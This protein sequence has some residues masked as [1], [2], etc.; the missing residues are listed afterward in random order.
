MYDTKYSSKTYTTYTTYTATT[1]TTTTA[2]SSTGTS[3]NTSA[4]TTPRTT[5]HTTTCTSSS[6]GDWRP[7]LLRLLLYILLRQNALATPPRHFDS[8]A[9]VLFF[10]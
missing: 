3:T 10:L 5:S 9:L 8:V 2:T 7:V 1:T 6:A 4:A